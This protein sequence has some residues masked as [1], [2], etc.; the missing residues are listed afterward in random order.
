MISSTLELLE[1][2]LKIHEA[3]I[4]GTS[5][6]RDLLLEIH[7]KRFRA[8]PESALKHHKTFLLDTPREESLEIIRRCE[9]QLYRTQKQPI[10][11][12]N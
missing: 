9:K 6:Q 12:L 10:K 7:C 5:S 4:A 2:W 11:T 8:E 1:S 3:Q